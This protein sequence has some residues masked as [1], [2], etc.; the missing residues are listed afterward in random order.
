MM[1]MQARKAAY[2]RTML[3]GRVWWDR[4]WTLVRVESSEMGTWLLC[5]LMY[6][7]EA[8]ALGGWLHSTRQL[9]IVKQK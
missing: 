1:R 4:A 2:R 9:N 8:V 7:A 6:F 3:A 5:V